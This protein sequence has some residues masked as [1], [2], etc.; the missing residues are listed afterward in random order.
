M[1][2]LSRPARRQGDRDVNKNILA[3]TA[4]LVGNAGY[5]R[6]LMDVTRH[7]DVSYSQDEQKVSRMI[8]SFFF[9]DVK[10]INDT[11]YE[12]KTSKKKLVM[13]LPIQI[14]FF[15]YQYAKLHMLRFYYEF[16]DHF[17]DRGDFELL[18]MDTDSA[19]MALA[20]ESLESLVKPELQ[21]EF[22]G[23]KNS[24]LPRTGVHA[25]YDKRTPGLFK[26]EW[27]GEGFVGLN[28]K[29]YACWGKDGDKVS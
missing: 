18:E 14:G 2:S 11:F 27:Q 15:V 8:N 1:A 9:K 5:G 21:E 4:K 13:K 29:T 23:A 19:Y 12:V 20:G 24:W 6:F 17:V 28:S 7:D 22:R 26:I 10:Q 3:E 16:L 25:A